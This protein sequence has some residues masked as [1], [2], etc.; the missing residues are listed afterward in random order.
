MQ[1]KTGLVLEGGGMRGMYTAGV[2]DVLMEQNISADLVV[3][4]SAG[5]LFGVNFLSHQNGR[6][7][8][9]NKKFNKDKRYMGLIP[10]LK[11]GNLVSTEYAYERVPRQLDPFDD[12]AFMANPASFYAVV[13]NTETGEAEYIEI[14]SGFAQMDVLRA[15]G[16]MPFV[17]KPVKIGNKSYLDGGIADSIPFRWASLQ[18][19][20]KLIVVL[21]QDMTYRKKPMSGLMI[22][23][24]KR[25]MPKIAARLKQRHRQYNEAV[26]ELVR[27]EKE[28]RA[29]VIRPSEPIEISKMER[30]PKKLQAVYDLGR[31]DARKEIGNLL[32]YMRWES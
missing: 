32:V 21:T 12:E 6:V 11:E 1:Q 26:E 15:S 2:L 28:G 5:A 30:D 22:N 18:G 25:K 4:V 29:F 3:G 16:S 9:Y 13:T 14:T 10:F 19:T 31:A 23:L 17:S 27:W 7:I 20:G 24:C 8:R